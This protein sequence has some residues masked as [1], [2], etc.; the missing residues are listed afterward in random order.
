ML[1][2]RGNYNIFELP[3]NPSEAMCITTNGIVKKD[4]KAV[5]GAGI[6]KQANSFYNYF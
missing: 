4:G 6:A 3:Q 2:L 5:M 1:E